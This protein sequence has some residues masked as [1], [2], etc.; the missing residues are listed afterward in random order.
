M[1]PNP[2]HIA[3][4]GYTQTVNT[5]GGVQ[6]FRKTYCTRTPLLPIIISR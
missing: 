6:T 2:P 1:L 3:V 4:K 5:H